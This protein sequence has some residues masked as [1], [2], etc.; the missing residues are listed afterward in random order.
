MRGKKKGSTR[1]KK[2]RSDTSSKAKKAY[3]RKSGRKGVVH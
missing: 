1:A 2:A 3:K